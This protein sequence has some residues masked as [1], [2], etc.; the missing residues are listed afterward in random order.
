MNESE[1]METRLVLVVV[2]QLRRMDQ[3]EA[4]KL[5]SYLHNVT[6]G[7]VRCLGRNSST[8]ASEGASHGVCS[9][10]VR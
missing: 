9:E 10:K 1:Y 2:P 5:S 3:N 7:I 4:H 8:R 6:N